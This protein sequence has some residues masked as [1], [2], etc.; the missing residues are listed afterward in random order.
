MIIDTLM[1]LWNSNWREKVLPVTIAF[2]VVGISMTIF[3]LLIGLPAFSQPSVVSNHSSVPASPEKSVSL[4][5]TSQAT[6]PPTIMSMLTPTPTTPP[7]PELTPA[8]AE[9]GIAYTPNTPIPGSL[10]VQMPGIVSNP[11]AGTAYLAPAASRDIDPPAAHTVAVTS[12]KHTSHPVKA[13]S[14]PVQPVVVTVTPT[15]T[16]TATATTA[17]STPTP[18]ATVQPTPTVGVTPEPVPTTT[19]GVTP[20]VVVPV[21]SSDPTPANSTPPV[22]T[23]GPIYSASPTATAPAVA[24]T[25]GVRP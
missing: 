24:S 14:V 23:S 3:F 18:T 6:V 5:I 19:Q 8:P 25:A 15:P 1:A 2:L 16:A 21:P 20:T 10:P 7:A 9:S 4:V 22:P 11:W 17:S 12:G 13:T